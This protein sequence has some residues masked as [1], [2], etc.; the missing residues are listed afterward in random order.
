M[1]NLM[2]GPLLGGNDGPAVERVNPL[3]SAPLALV[4]EHA[5]NRLPERLGT[6]GL[7]R[8][9]LEDHIAWD[10]GAASV[11]EHLANLID[12]QAVLQRFSRL[13][14][15]CNRAPGSEDA[16]PLQYGGRRIPGN[17]SLDPD[18]IRARHDGLYVPFHAAVEAGLNTIG[19][20][21]PLMLLLSIQTF[22]PESCGGEVCDVGVFSGRDNRLGQSLV[23]AIEHDKGYRVRS[24]WPF[25]PL[26]AVTHTLTKHGARKNVVGAMLAINNRLVWDAARQERMARY[27][28][29][30]LRSIVENGLAVR[31]QDAPER[32]LTSGVL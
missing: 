11:T 16:V 1:G 18:A 15:N 5:S 26:D 27:L 22:D 9:A 31:T 8:D 10:V 14:Y 29:A 19:R 21:R 24:D 13:A 12:A 30:V 32:V 17:Q 23:S 7:M 4:C 25:S 20:R 3:G 28:A 2:L 6:L